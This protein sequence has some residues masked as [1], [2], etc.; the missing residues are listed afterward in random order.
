MPRPNPPP[1]PGSSS[2]IRGKEGTAAASTFNLPPTAYQEQADRLSTSSATPSANGSDSSYRPVSP[3]L[4][5]DTPRK[6]PSSHHGPVITRDDFALPP[7]PT[8]S[9]KI[10]QM[11]PRESDVHET[12]TVSASSQPANGKGGAQAGSKRK[13][14]STGQTA[15][16]RKIARKTAHSLIERRRRSKMNE[17]FGVLKDMIPACKGQ[18][19]HKL[20]ILQASIEY[21]RY[22][23]QCVADLQAK[24]SSPQPQPPMRRRDV[25]E[26]AV[27]EDDDEEMEDSVGEPEEGTSTLATST[28]EKSGSLVS[29]PSLSQITTTTTTSPSI[30]PIGNGGRHY[31]ISSAA[32]SYSPYFHSNQASPAFGPQ[33]H[34]VSTAPSFSNVF[35]LGS[36]ALKPLDSAGHLRQIAEGATELSEKHGHSQAQRPASKGRRD[37]SEH[38]MDQE[39]T[40]ALLMLNHDRRSWKAANAPREEGGDCRSSGMSVR[41]LLS[42]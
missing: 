9:R 5:A 4:P 18:E 23:E 41:D 32:S 19:M 6:R 42:G 14:N 37:E 8:R 7:P 31:S 3:G 16:G 33:L 24:K 11:K 40:A 30:F 20:A 17:E 21:L 27:D 25:E 22:L 1:T 29:L 39:A 36:P 12:P 13:Q 28:L 26:E 34:H 35:G 10:I 38:Q 2:D 15:A